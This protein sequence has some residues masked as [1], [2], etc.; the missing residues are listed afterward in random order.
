MKTS[1]FFINFGSISLYH[2]FYSDWD[3]LEAITNVYAHTFILSSEREDFEKWCKIFINCN[4]FLIWVFEKNFW[5]PIKELGVTLARHHNSLLC[6]LVPLS[7]Y[8]QR[9]H[10][11]VPWFYKHLPYYRV[12]ILAYIQVFLFQ[13]NHEGQASDR[14]KRDGRT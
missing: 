1:E 6:D 14:G 9:P 4:S 8:K 12:Q 10:H 13:N 7:A 3:F 2:I 11:L 5:V